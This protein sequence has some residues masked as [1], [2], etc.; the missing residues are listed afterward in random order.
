MHRCFECESCA[1]HLQPL[2]VGSTEDWLFL[3][4]EAALVLFV[5]RFLKKDEAGWSRMNSFGSASKGVPTRLWLVKSCK[6]SKSLIRTC[7]N[8]LRVACIFRLQMLV[9]S[10]YSIVSTYMQ[11]LSNNIT[12]KCPLSLQ[13]DPILILIFIKWSKVRLL[14]QKPGQDWCASQPGP[15]RSNC[16]TFSLRG[17]LWRKR[18]NSWASRPKTARFRWPSSSELRMDENGILCYMKLWNHLGIPIENPRLALR[19]DY[20]LDAWNVLDWF[21]LIMMIITVCYKVDTWSKAGGLYVISPSNW[22]S[23]T[24]DMYSNFHGVASNVRLSPERWTCFI[25]FYLGSIFC[26][27]M[28]ITSH[29]ANVPRTNTEFDIIQHHPHLVQGG[30]VHQHHSLCDQ[31]ED[32]RPFC[33][34]ACLGAEEVPT[35]FAWLLLVWRHVFEPFLLESSP[36]R[37]GGNF[38]KVSWL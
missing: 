31:S 33:Q 22:D 8:A 7:Q 19:W 25:M 21:N 32:Q 2:G 38:K 24:K 13:S 10:Q 11:S 28:L 29:C 36:P 34:A 18:L 12:T 35:R 17:M 15:T 1:R 20:F 26:F 6:V 5:L 9:K 16:F 30:Q 3:I 14:P 23:V 4:L 27:G 37:Q